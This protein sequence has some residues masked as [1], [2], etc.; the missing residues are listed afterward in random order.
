M[1]LEFSSPSISLSIH[2]H[3]SLAIPP[4]SLLPCAVPPFSENS[5]W[6]VLGHGARLLLIG[7]V[8][9]GQTQMREPTGGYVFQELFVSP[10]DVL[11]APSELSQPMSGIEYPV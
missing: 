5:R 6:V 10:R 11:D 1:V 4:S 7:K 2:L 9:A 3:L 8:C